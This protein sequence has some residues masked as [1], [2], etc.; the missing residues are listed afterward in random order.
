MNAIP[1]VIEAHTRAV[2]AFTQWMLEISNSASM[3]MMI[4]VAH[5][6]GLFDTMAKMPPSNSSKIATA[7]GLRERYV[8]ECLGALT[9][10]GIVR[11]DASNGTYM[12]P[13]EH[14]ARLTRD[15]YP[16][17]MASMMQWVS[18]LGAVEDEIIRCFREGGGVP[19]ERFHRFHEAM[20][21]ESDQTTIGGMMEHILPA[22]PGLKE[23]LVRGID[24]VDIGCGAG[25]AMLFLAERFPRSRFRGFDF[26]AEAIGM[27]TKM[28]SERRLK[29]VH[30]EQRDVTNMPE[31]Q[32]FDLIT[33]FDAIH[34][35][36]HPAMVLRNIQQA[37][38]N[39]GTFL[40][41][42]IRASSH[43]E[44][45]IGQPLAPFLYTIS[46]MHCMTVSLACGGCGLGTCWGEELARDMLRDAGFS[47]VEVKQLEHDILNNYYICMK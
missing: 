6:T 43:L 29:N 15:A 2:D 24:V 38:R 20:A 42:D 17:N 36:A 31:R 25:K 11:Y 32:E 21:E 8:R 4:S 9:A 22:I 27:A 13:P 16:T 14:A 18:V 33:A 28:A 10:G 45:N 35:Q 46:T 44:K 3:A 30:F 12:L 41:Q 40:M 39:D 7:A 26:S 34:D 19:Y 37:L 1:E 23:R 5:R 47:R